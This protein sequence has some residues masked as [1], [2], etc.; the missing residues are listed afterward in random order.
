[1]RTRQTG[2]TLIELLVVIAIIAILAAILFPVFAQAREQARK[3]SCTSNLRQAATAVLM[4]AQDYDETF[5]ISLYLGREANGAMCT[6]SFYAEVVPYQKNAD[7][8]KCPSDVPPMDAAV[9][10][11]NVRLFPLCATNPPAKD[12][13]YMFNFAVIEQGYPNVVFPMMDPRRVVRTMAELP[14]VAET[15]LVFDGTATLPGGSRGYA[16]FDTPVQARHA[17]MSVANFADG[18]AK[19]VKV[20]PTLN[21]NANQLGGLRLD[22]RPILD[23]TVT[24]KGPYENKNSLFG[25]AY[26]RSDGSWCSGIPGDCP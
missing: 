17:R 4:Y 6:M 15:S 18:H 21:G 11:A 1:M 5:P 7:V 24:D 26:Q 2:F 13:S 3:T 22:G 20:K 9:G 25:I 23:W 16:V 19:V 10:L 12:I 8:M 14:H